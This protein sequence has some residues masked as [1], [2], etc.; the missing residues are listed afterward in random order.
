MGRGG[1]VLDLTMERNT[2]LEIEPRPDLL[3]GVVV[4]KGTAMD[5]SKTE[6]GQIEKTARQFQAI[7]YYAWAHRGKGQMAVWISA[8]DPP[9][10]ALPKQPASD[11]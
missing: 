8:S 5:K 2:P 10:I 1:K 4:I 3:G 9:Y 6:D 11:L 7:P